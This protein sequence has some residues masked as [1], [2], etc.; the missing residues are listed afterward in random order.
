MK[1]GQASQQI[2]SQIIFASGGSGLGS[3]ASEK[4]PWRLDEVEKLRWWLDEAEKL[5]WWLDEA[6]KHRW[7]LDEAEKT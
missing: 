2:F 1:M 3:V 5:R 7:W 6:E 4:L